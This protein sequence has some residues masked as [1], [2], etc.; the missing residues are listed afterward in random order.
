M[1]YLLALKP[2]VAPKML[3]S[4][5]IDDKLITEFR[6][7]IS[8]IAWVGVT[9][10]CAQA[11][12]SLYQHVL[13]KPLYEDLLK[14]NACLE[15]LQLEYKPIIFR[16]GLSLDKLRITTICD[17]SLGNAEKYSQ[18]GY[19]HM[20]S[21][22]HQEVLCGPMAM[23]TARS[24]RSKRV[25]SSTSAA[26]TLAMVSGVESGQFL[27]TWLAELLHPQASA[28]DLLAMAGASLPPHDVGTDCGDLVENLLKPAMPQPAQKSLALYLACLR[29]TKS[30]ESTRAWLWVDTEDNLANGLTKLTP[31]GLIMITEISHALCNSWWEP[32]KAF[33][34]NG[35]M[36][37][38]SGMRIVPAVIRIRPKAKPKPI[39][40]APIAESAT[41]VESLIASGTSSASFVQHYPAI[42]ENTVPTYHYD[43]TTTDDDH[44]YVE[45]TNLTYQWSLYDEDEHND[46]SN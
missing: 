30:L 43:L 2:I 38:P 42:S 7:L 24:V 12:A 18:G 34:W 32:T 13:P 8:G 25:A 11:A 23:I 31:T 46:D 45:E 4:K 15:Q 3:L 17:S 14:L 20:L 28:S 40:S 27:Q 35:V 41:E 9:N 36:T 6:S 5:E 33:K 37:F 29:E 1:A 21:D 19:V 39:A 44:N 16:H 22:D 26:E 10:P